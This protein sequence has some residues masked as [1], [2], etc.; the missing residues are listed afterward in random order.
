MRYA[1]ILSGL[2]LC[3]SVMLVTTRCENDISSLDKSQCEQN[4]GTHPTWVQ[5]LIQELGS[6]PVTNPPS[7]VWRY[8]YDNRSVYYIPPVCCDLPG[9]LFSDSGE[10]LCHPDG[11]IS[12]TGD[13]RCPDFFQTRSCEE[14]V[15]SDDR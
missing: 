13:G 2:G 14:H 15:W 7:S 9:K 1:F 3:V 4:A 11:G 6:Q 10:L 12:G 5:E 8:R